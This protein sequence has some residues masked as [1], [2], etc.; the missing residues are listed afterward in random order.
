M[1]A[2]PE[3]LAHGDVGSGLEPSEPVEIQ[4]LAPCGCKQAGSLRR[5]PQRRPAGL[6]TLLL[7]GLD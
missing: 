5:F 6:G 4:R 3:D 7:E 1:A 2:P